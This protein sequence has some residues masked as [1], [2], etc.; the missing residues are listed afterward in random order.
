MGSVDGCPGHFA[1]RVLC[2]LFHDRNLCGLL[3][4]KVSM[5]APEN[6]PGLEMKPFLRAQLERT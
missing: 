1:Y 4:S 2:P 5:F 3:P 6:K